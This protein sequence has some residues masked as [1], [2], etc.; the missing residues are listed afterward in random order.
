MEF[1]LILW[2]P[3]FQ[4]GSQT[5]NKTNS[6]L[7]ANYCNRTLEPKSWLPVLVIPVLEEL[8]DIKPAISLEWTILEPIW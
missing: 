6:N 8:F 3:Q 2:R 4:N 5:I 1:D 7:Y